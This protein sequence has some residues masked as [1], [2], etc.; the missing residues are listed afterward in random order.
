MA[1]EY[2][3]I[4]DENDQVIGRELRSVIH[5][6][7][8]L[9]REVHV[10]FVTPD[11]QLIFQKRSMMKDTYP[12][13]WCET[14]GGHVKPGQDY[15]SAAAAEACEETGLPVTLDD[16]ILI[17]KIHLHVPT[18]N[19][20]IN[21]TLRCVY[22]YKRPVSLD[23]LQIESGEATEFVCRDVDDFVSGTIDLRPLAIPTLFEKPYTDVWPRL[24]SMLRTMV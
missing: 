5:Q 14:V 10:W 11:K 2:L 7:G 18:G 9:H 23:N 19:G 8:L 15:I 13:L 6:K 24:Q 22:L 16:L 4:V 20:L 12:G 21:N 3:D 1:D 17:D